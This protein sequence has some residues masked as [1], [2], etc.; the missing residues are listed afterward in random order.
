VES[1]GV[2]GYAMDYEKELELY[3]SYCGSYC[4]T[5]VWFTG[6]I[7]RV[8][9]EALRTF[10]EYGLGR[11]LAGI[12]DADA[13]RDGL[14]RLSESG[15]CSGCKAE[16]KEKP[17]EDRCKIRQCAHSKG[18]LLCSE[19]PEFPCNMLK[20]H[21]GVVKFGCIENLIEIKEK[22][23][24]NWVKKQWREYVKSMIR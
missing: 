14:V 7:R 9:R 21:P 3:I 19:C 8:F 2:P 1:Q 17:G 15:I 6:E 22:G 16:V 5:C 20:S 11:R 23:V 10:D 13:F 12:I 4:H 24:E 18:Y